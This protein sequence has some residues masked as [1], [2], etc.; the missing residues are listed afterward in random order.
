M[1]WDNG[2]KTY[3]I[4]YKKKN[5]KIKKLKKNISNKNIFA[6]DFKS[7]IQ[8]NTDN[9]LIQSLKTGKANLF[10]WRSDQ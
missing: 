10:Y 4:S 8:K 6:L 7:Q 5:N 3:I 1:I 2:I 9:S